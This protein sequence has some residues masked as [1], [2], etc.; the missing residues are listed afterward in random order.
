MQLGKGVDKLNRN[1]MSFGLVMASNVEAIIVFFMA[2]KC[3]PWLN[4]LFPRPGGWQKWTYLAAVLVVGVL[5]F[6]LFRTLI[7]RSKQQTG[8]DGK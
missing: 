2:H 3:A 6:R 4:E 5:W 7:K 8:D 1:Y